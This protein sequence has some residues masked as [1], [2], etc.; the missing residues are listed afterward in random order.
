MAQYERIAAAVVCGTSGSD[1]TRLAFQRPISDLGPETLLRVSHSDARR[2]GRFPVS[3][4]KAGD[5][6]GTRQSQR[7]NGR[8]KEMDRVAAVSTLAF[9]PKP[10]RSIMC[11]V[12]WVK[13]LRPAESRAISGLSAA[14]AQP[15]PR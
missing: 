6:H 12:R 14:M 9:P 13:G 11:F 15:D 7:P 5:V 4:R 8:R 1:I 2:R 3:G 10:G